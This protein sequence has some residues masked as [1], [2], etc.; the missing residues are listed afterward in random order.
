[1]K[2]KNFLQKYSWTSITIIYR[3]C[4]SPTSSKDAKIGVKN[5][6]NTFW[7]EKLKFD[8][9]IENA[10]KSKTGYRASIIHHCYAI[11]GGGEGGEGGDLMLTVWPQNE[12]HQF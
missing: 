3:F 6:H 5:R 4:T 7:D 12:N 10:M 8:T 1:M 2:N 11:G 9:V